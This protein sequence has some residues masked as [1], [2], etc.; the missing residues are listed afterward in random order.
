MRVNS[1]FI[2]FCRSAI[3]NCRRRPV[4]VIVL[5]AGRFHKSRTATAALWHLWQHQLLHV[6]ARSSANPSSRWQQFARTA[7]GIPHHRLRTERSS[8]T[9]AKPFSVQPRGLRQSLP[10]RRTSEDL[11]LSLH[12]GTLQCSGR[13]SIHAAC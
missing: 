3:S 4:H 9:E 13:V 5:V 8:W 6:D 2:Q 1:L 12:P 7:T 11:L 10:R